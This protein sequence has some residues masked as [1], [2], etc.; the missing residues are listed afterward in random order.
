V[1]ALGFKW[2]VPRAGYAKTW[3]KVKAQCDQEIVKHTD[4]PAGTGRAY[5]DR[6]TS[7]GSDAFYIT[8]QRQQHRQAEVGLL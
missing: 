2:E 1:L 4:V 8:R 7:T 3:D 6:F 5:P